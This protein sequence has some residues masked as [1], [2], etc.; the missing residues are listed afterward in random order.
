MVKICHAA[1]LPSFPGR[2]MVI[3]LIDLFL[4]NHLLKRKCLHPLFTGL[5]IFCSSV[6]RVVIFLNS[7]YFVGDLTIIYSIVNV[8]V[9]F[10]CLSES[11]TSQV[12]FS[13]PFF[14]PA[15]SITRST[16]STTT[17]VTWLYMKPLL[18]FSSRKLSQ[19]PRLALYFFFLF[20]FA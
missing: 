12:L 2:E 17:V 6:F 1:Q 9:P 8:I 13:V 7:T 19:D 3:H 14:L 18:E 20:F 16:T 4:T 15:V 11:N 10:I 5:F